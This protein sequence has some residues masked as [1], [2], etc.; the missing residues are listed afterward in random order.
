MELKIINLIARFAKGGVLHREE[1]KNDA[2]GISRL[3][4]HG[5]LKKVHR[6]RRIFYELTEKALPVLEA[7]RRCLLE[8]VRMLADLHKPPSVFHALL[9][10]VR[11]LDDKHAASDCFKL[12]GDWQLTRPVVPSQLELAKLRYYE[13]IFGEKR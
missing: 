7:R 9:D 2:R 3:L 12:L 1:V 8:E 4:R 5:F 6:N 13:N 11:F 10:D